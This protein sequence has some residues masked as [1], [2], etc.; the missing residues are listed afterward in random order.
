M[1]IR[2]ESGLLKIERSL[3]ALIFGWENE[4]EQDGIDGQWLYFITGKIRGILEKC[5]ILSDKVLSLNLSGVTPESHQNALKAMEMC[6]IEM[7]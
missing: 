4:G 3:G 5:L 7:I 1:E 2:M 6:Q